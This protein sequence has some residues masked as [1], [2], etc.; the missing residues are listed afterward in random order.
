LL[1]HA[2]EHRRRRQALCEYLHA[3]RDAGNHHPG[4]LRARGRGASHRM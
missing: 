4:A 1:L 3:A 2:K